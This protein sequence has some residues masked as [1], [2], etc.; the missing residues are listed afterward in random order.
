LNKKILYYCI[1]T[2]VILSM[3]S[4]GGNKGVKMPP[5]RETYA[6]KDKNPFGGYAAYQFIEQL[7]PLN[8]VR[9]KKQSFDKTWSD[10]EYNDT[11]SLYVCIAPKLFV[12]ED[13]TKAMLDYVRAGNDLFIAANWIDE[14]LL[15]EIKLT[16]DKT[17]LFNLFGLDSFRNTQTFS[18]VQT[19]NSYQYYYK[20]FSNSFKIKD[21]VFTK[22]LGTNENNEPNFIVFFHGKGKLFLHCDARAFSNYF[23]LKNDNYSYLEKSLSYTH[24][25]PQRLYWDDYYRKLTYK[26]DDKKEHSSFSEILKHPPLATAFWLSLL[27]LGL[28]ILFGGKRRQR[29]I[30]L[31]KPN[32]NTTVAFTETIGRLYLQNKNN[33]NI[34]D[35]MIMYFNEHVRN[36]YYLN[37][38]TINNDFLTTLSR[39]SGVE[40]TQVETLYRTILHAQQQY[41]I[42]DFEL[43]SLNNQIQQFYKKK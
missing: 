6:N 23:V 38:N 30:P 41:Q 31:V 24:T 27:L 28:Y 16:Q 11:A 26:K 15:T 33:K 21:S 25:K 9:E 22:V 18:K 37:T 35:K 14:D 36:H 1:V 43:L 3:L 39:K 2:L 32:E 17:N 40:F 10:I 19:S 34:A 5:L 7:F 12:N 4:C 42:N 8:A 13:E 20:S 29:E